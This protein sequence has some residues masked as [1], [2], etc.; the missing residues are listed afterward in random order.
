MQGISKFS[1]I[2]IIMMLVLVIAFAGLGTIFTLFTPLVETAKF[3]LIFAMLFLIITFQ[4][5]ILE[6][7]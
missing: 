5:L 6:K 2:A 7:K 3:F 4:I 1:R